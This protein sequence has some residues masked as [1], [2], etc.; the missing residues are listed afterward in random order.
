MH[1]EFLTTLLDY[2]VLWRNV[3]IHSML[4]SVERKKKQKEKDQV[5]NVDESN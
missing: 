4:L 1:S 5:K 3:L 2:I